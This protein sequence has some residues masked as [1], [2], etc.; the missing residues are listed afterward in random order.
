MAPCI[1]E[2]MNSIYKEILIRQRIHEIYFIAT[3]SEFKSKKSEKII[4]K[5]VLI[6]KNF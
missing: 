1:I 4:S 6:K 3:A 2:K 5:Q